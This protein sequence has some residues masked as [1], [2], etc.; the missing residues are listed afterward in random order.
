MSNRTR[1]HEFFLK[2][3]LHTG[4]KQRQQLI[5]IAT[6]EQMN[7][8]REIVLNLYLGQPPVSTYY[9]SK[10]KSFKKVIQSISDRQV[11]NIS[12]KRLVSKHIGVVPLVLRPHFRDGGRI[13]SVE[14]NN[15]RSN[16]KETD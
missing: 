7:A 10:L 16:E 15:V 12:V 2:L 3:L 14:E 6:D 1:R 4:Q 5:T 8:F 13:P 11:N 9:R